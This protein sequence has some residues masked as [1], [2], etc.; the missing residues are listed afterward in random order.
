MRHR[1][2]FWGLQR[3]VMPQTT[4]RGPGPTQGEVVLDPG[5]ARLDSTLASGSEGSGAFGADLAMPALVGVV[6]LVSHSSDGTLGPED[7]ESDGGGDGEGDGGGDVDA[8]VA[9]T[10]EYG[11]PAE[12]EEGEVE[13]GG[14]AGGQPLIGGLD[15]IG[16]PD[17]LPVG[18]QEAGVRAGLLERAASEVEEEVEEAELVEEEVVM[19]VEEEEEEEDKD[20]VGRGVERRAGG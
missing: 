10:A 14:E 13:E 6:T 7:G 20:G 19:V 5:R 11:M 1:A 2:S 15:Q 12:E 9:V 16:S 18:S 8:A 4:A 17:L 3:E